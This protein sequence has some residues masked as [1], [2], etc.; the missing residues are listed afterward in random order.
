MR[1]SV[2]AQ[3]AR[4]NPKQAVARNAKAA[5]DRR[6]S[7]RPAPDCMTYLTAL[8]PVVQGVAVFAA[9][10]RHADTVFADGDERGRGQV[11]ADELVA[12]IHRR[13]RSHQQPGHDRPHPAR[14][15]RRARGARRP[16]PDPRQPRAAPG[17]R[18]PQVR[19]GVHPATVPGP[20][21]QP[22]PRRPE[23]P[24]PRAS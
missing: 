20:R 8:L 19:S 13:G 18:G 22:H 3:V 6:V 5:N 23:T 10:R 9:L 1:R 24:P 4:L 11:M 7:L 12:R 21:R 16:R 17:P 2:G 14:P 15:R